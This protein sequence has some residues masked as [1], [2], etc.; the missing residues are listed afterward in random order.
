MI[1][2]VSLKM[3]RSIT[4][5]NNTLSNTDEHYLINKNMSTPPPPSLSND[6]PEHHITKINGILQDNIIYSKKNNNNNNEISYGVSKLN[7]MLK[8]T[9]KKKKKR[10][11]NRSKSAIITSTQNHTR[12]HQSN[13][14]MALLN[15]DEK[16][17]IKFQYELN[18]KIQNK[19]DILRPIKKSLEI[20]SDITQKITCIGP[21]R[22]GKTSLLKILSGGQFNCN[23]NPTIKLPNK[24]FEYTQLI[25]TNIKE[26]FGVKYMLFD[27]PGQALLRDVAKLEINGKQL[28]LVMFAIDDSNTYYDAINVWL[29]YLHDHAKGYDRIILIGNKIDNEINRCVQFFDAYNY[30]IGRGIM[31]LEIS[32]KTGKNI[33]TLINLINSYTSMKIHTNNINNNNTINNNNNND[34]DISSSTTKSSTKMAQFD[35]ITRYDSESIIRIQNGNIILQNT[36]DVSDVNVRDNSKR[37]C[38]GNKSCT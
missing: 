7:E 12:K 24:A 29:T 28:I 8:S 10:R 16:Q 20:N 15:D 23:E 22:V 25:D 18:S 30:V 19:S 3:S 33:D 1:S 13:S 2:K 31:Y 34:D 26:S 38:D 27:T 14:D 5:E 37:K 17:A 9:K 35:G 36:D 32:C 11:D 6:L 4:Y 21:A